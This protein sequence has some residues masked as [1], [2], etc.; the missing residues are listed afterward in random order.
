MNDIRLLTRKQLEDLLGWSKSSIYQKM[1]R[2][3]FP[4][5]IHFGR[6]VRWRYID[7][8]EFEKNGGMK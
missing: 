1:A 4:K 6:T 5:P 3:E 7:I 8:E 2:N